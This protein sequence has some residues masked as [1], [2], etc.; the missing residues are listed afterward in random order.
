MK[1]CFLFLFICFS[2]SSCTSFGELTMGAIT[3][4]HITKAASSTKKSDEF[5][6]SSSTYITNSPKSTVLTALLPGKETSGRSEQIKTSFSTYIT[7]YPKS[8]V[9]ESTTYI[10]NPL[11]STVLTAIPPRKETSEKSEEVKTSFSKNITKYPKSTVVTTLLTLK[12]PDSIASNPSSHRANLQFWHI[13]L[14]LVFAMIVCLG[15]LFASIRYKR[16]M[17][18]SFHLP[19]PV[20]NWLDRP[21]E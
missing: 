3:T 13:L 7:K 20:L 16:S 5:Q 17:S 12:D 9:A 10:T 4:D 14:V 1:M 2:A 8:T 15:L 11:Q 19:Y 21:M 6:T 18:R